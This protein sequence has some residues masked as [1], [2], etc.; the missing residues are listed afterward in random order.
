LNFLPLL[1]KLN[2]YNSSFL[3]FGPEAARDFFEIYK[4][5]FYKGFF[6]AGIFWFLDLMFF[7]F[8]CVLFRVLVYLGLLGFFKGV[9]GFRDFVRF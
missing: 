9:R 1:E 2:L 4:G 6:F 8:F 3:D 5:I 7:G